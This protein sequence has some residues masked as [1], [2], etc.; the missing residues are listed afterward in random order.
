MAK[1]EG[2]AV[3]SSLAHARSFSW[4]KT[5]VSHTYSESMRLRGSW[6]W[7]VPVQKSLKF[8]E[9]NPSPMYTLTNTTENKGPEKA[10]QV[11]LR[12]EGCSEG[13]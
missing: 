7:G 8:S 1:D 2:N 11:I 3:D 4:W 12:K 10:Q 9:L 5:I 6:A 13:R